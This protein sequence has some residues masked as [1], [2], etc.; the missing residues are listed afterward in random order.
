MTHNASLHATTG[1]LGVKGVQCCVLAGSKL[2]LLYTMT[3]SASISVS[4]MTLTLRGLHLLTSVLLLP[5]LLRK[6]LKNQ[7][8]VAC[9]LML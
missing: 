4:V 5:V 3:V 6:M 7:M 8:C 9:L 1:F 2:E